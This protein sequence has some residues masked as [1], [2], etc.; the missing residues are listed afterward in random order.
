M[1]E[2]K[3]WLVWLEVAAHTRTQG[4]AAGPVWYGI[5]M[6]HA[7]TCKSC[8]PLP[9]SKNFIIAKMP[10]ML[11]IL[12]AN[13]TTFWEANGSRTNIQNRYLQDALSST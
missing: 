13:S 1:K 2:E 12:C 4:T 6:R 10:T 8:I 11:H 5:G 9:P 7:E 3:R